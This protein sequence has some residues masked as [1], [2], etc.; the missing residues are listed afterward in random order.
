MALHATVF[1]QCSWLKCELAVCLLNTKHNLA[2]KKA[3]LA[4]MKIGF[5]VY[6][7]F[8]NGTRSFF[9]ALNMKWWIESHIAL[10]VYTPLCHIPLLSNSKLTLYSIPTMN[11][12][13][14]RKVLWT[15][16]LLSCLPTWTKSYDGNLGGNTHIQTNQLS[17]IS[18]CATRQ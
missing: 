9:S 18:T 11:L 15:S 4:K 8:E 12:Y 6:A 1:M 2:N 3:L 14:D 7:N 13:K 10:K 17:L 5:V 16:I